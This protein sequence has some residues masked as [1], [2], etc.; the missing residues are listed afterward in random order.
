MTRTAA[1][2]TSDFYKASP[3]IRLFRLALAASERLWPA[4]AVHAAS[5][6]FLT[7]LPGKW[8]S[9]RHRWEGRWHATSWAFED[10]SLTVYSPAA[11]PHAPV[12]LLVHG[13][14]GSA[15]QMLPLAETLAAQ[16]LRPVLVDMP[17]HGR[18][19]GSTSALPQFARAIEYVVARL[20]QQGFELHALVAHSLGASAAAYV[21]SRGVGIGRLVLLAPPASP[22]EYTRLFAQVFGLSERTRA[23]MQGRIEARQGMLMRVFQPEAVG[24]RI[25]V[26]TLIVHDR[27]DSINRFVDGQSYAH[28]VRG[29][30][31]LATEGLGHRKI[32]KDAQVLGRVALFLR[33]PEAAP[34]LYLSASQYESSSCG[35]VRIIHGQTCACR[36]ERMHIAVPGRVIEHESESRHPGAGLRPGETACGNVKMLLN[37]HPSRDPFAIWRMVDEAHRAERRQARRRRV[38]SRPQVGRSKIGQPRLQ[39]P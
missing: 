31:L 34:V 2:A 20:R 21:A 29:A 15:Q 14:G 23:A 22:P 12:V 3:G 18:S 32:L 36:S 38:L 1:Q 13:W 35:S 6:L 33:R 4:L 37:N 28:A 11:P 7:P 17:A 30:E 27:G 19:A 10:A 24:P 25:H 8:L 16:G 9:R 39:P 26:P 5:R